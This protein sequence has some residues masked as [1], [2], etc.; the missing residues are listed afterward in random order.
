MHSE[1]WRKSFAAPVLT[2]PTLWL[3]RAAPELSAHTA[4]CQIYQD[5]QEQSPLQ[6]L[7]HPWSGEVL[8]FLVFKYS[9]SEEWLM[10]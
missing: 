8:L 6:T 10:D 5:K 7:C 4:W 3:G 2:V 9:G 1:Q